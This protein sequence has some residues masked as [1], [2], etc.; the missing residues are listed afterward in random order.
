MRTTTLSIPLALALATSGCAIVSTNPVGPSGDA[1][2]S[3]G[4]PYMLPKALLPVEL[5]VNGPAIRID[6]LEPVFV[7]DPDHVYLLRHNASPFSSDDIKLEVDPKTSLLKSVTLESKDETGEVLKKLIAST[8]RAE[9]A[10][11]GEETVALQTL[12]DPDDDQSISAVSTALGQAVMAHLARLGAACKAAPPPTPPA[13]ADA[14]CQQVEML[15]KSGQPDAGIRVSLMATDAARARLA[16]ARPD[17]TSGIYHRASLP[18]RVDLSLFGQSRS[19][20]VLLPNKGPTLSLPLN[21][22]A[23]VTVKHSVALRNGVIEKYETTKP[24]AAL[25]LVSWPLDVYD[26]VVTT[27]AK[28]IQLKIDTSRNALSLQQQIVDEA[29]KRKAL[30]DQLKAIQNTRAE[31]ATLIGMGNANKLLTVGTGLPPSA[32]PTG[33]R[34][35]AAAQPARD[36]TVKPPAPQPGLILGSDGKPAKTP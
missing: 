18:Y 31:S 6:V 36:D 10:T 19:T 5:V 28:V 13:A 7:G 16:D 8:L 25:A 20:V 12:V 27:T 22:Q 24:S 17:D 9:S 29:G 11:S 14:S 34:V 3:A 26:A 21:G 1:T 35:G 32:L 15:R 23:F 2:G 33:A 30:E 4:V